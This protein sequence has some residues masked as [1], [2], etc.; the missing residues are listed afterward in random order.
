[1]LLAFSSETLIFLNSHNKSI[2]VCHLQETEFLMHN[3]QSLLMSKYKP[4]CHGISGLHHIII[5]KLAVRPA[6]GAGLDAGNGK[7]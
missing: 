6:F 3:L 4:S 2:P 1:M 5:Q 7:Q